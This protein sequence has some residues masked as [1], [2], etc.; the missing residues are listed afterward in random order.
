MSRPAGNVAVLVVVVSFHT[1]APLVAAS[2]AQDE[3]K[4]EC[5]LALCAREVGEVLG[6]WNSWL[7]CNLTCRGLDSLASLALLDPG[8][9]RTN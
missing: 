4:E 9:I 8:E 1:S 7:H 5:G 6:I 2:P 3:R